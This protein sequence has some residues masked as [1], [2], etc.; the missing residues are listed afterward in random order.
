MCVERV[1]SIIIAILIGFSLG[2]LGS[3]NLPLMVIINLALIVVLLID[4]FSG[5]CPI[6]A[7][8]SKILP[9][10]EDR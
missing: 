9:K 3:K 10:C 7:V 8:L 1:R 2:F 4:G 5:F 6:R